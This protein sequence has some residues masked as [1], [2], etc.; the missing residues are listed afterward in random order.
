MRPI[1]NTPVPARPLSR[2]GLL[3]A[4]LALPLAAPAL[5]RAAA[6][7]ATRVSLLHFNDFHSHLE[8]IVAGGAACRANATCFGGAARLATA[9]AQGRAAARAEG[10]APLLLDG[11]DEFTGTLFFTRHR[12]MAEAAMQRELGVQAMTLGNHEFDRGP[13]LLGAYLA[14]LPFPIV[15]AN[16]DLADEPALREQVIPWTVLRAGRQRFAVI[17]LTTPETANIASPG[18]N[19]RFG[20][21]AVATERAIAEIRAKE[22]GATVMLLSHCGL[23]A[24]RMLARQVAGIDLIVGGHSH[25][26]LA[27]GLAEAEGP[28]PVLEDGPDRPVRIVQAGAYGRYLGRL[29]LD[30][31]ESG[32]IAGHA[33]LVRELGADVA[34]DPVM[35]AIVATFAA[36]L[37]ELRRSVVARIPETLSIDGCRVG[38]CAIGNL[39]AD[40]LL[41]ATPRAEVALSNAGGIRAGLVAGNVTMGDVLAM[42]PFNNTAVVMRLRGDDLRLALENGVSQV[43]ATAGRFPVFAGLRAAWDP[44]APEGK[45]VTV[46]E[47]A[48][49]PFDPGALYRVVTNNFMAR[50]GDGYD[51]LRDGGQEV[52]DIGTPLQDPL[53]DFLTAGRPLPGIDGRLGR[54]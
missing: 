41:A 50:G 35:A 25:T 16:L 37:E 46:L 44:N 48:G 38:E 20:D 24:D 40:S 22:P 11:G 14:T 12:G 53:I 29:D 42:L 36:P 7:P 17:G 21:P 47:V 6:D 26:L 33:G 51:S 18:P 5:R 8:P 19:V 49:K 3:G 43:A 54:R 45:R 2:R 27:N 31:A 30:L 13:A 4:A 10:R 32:R 39:M 34:P 1:C 23:L 28:A 9:V 52:V 15:S